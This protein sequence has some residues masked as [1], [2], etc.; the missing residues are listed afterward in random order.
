[1]TKLQLGGHCI[2]NDLTWRQGLWPTLGSADGSG[3]INGG[4]PPKANLSAHLAAVREQLSACIPDPEFNGLGVLDLEQWDPAWEMNNCTFAGHNVYPADCPGD[5]W[6]GAYQEATRSFIRETHPSWAHNTS[7]VEAESKAAWETSATQFFVQTLDLLHELR[8]KMKWGVYQVPY[9]LH[10]PCARE[11]G[12][13]RCGFDHPEWGPKVRGLY[14]R[15]PI[16]SVFV[17]SRVLA[18]SIYVSANVSADIQEAYVRSNVEEAR[19]LASI[20]RQL[21]ES[22]APVVAFGELYYHGQL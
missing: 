15:E 22:R 9:K 5:G 6:R 8:P 3:P 18:P 17:A 10:G 11:N 2:A 14:E 21:S 1:M 20:G 13:Y 16:T 7:R 12:T 19:R 4:I